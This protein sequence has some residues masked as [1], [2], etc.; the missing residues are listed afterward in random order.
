MT[1]RTVE[2]E[3]AVAVAVAVCS[4]VTVRLS[5]TEVNRALRLHL[6]E[7]LAPKQAPAPSDLDKIIVWISVSDDGVPSGAT[8][9]Y[10]PAKVIAAPKDIEVTAPMIEAGASIFGE[11]WGG[12]Q[13]CEGAARRIFDAMMAAR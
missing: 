4:A 9:E 10:E 5:A 12:N 13:D 1:R 7:R 2:P 11:E 6:A 3:P 8:I